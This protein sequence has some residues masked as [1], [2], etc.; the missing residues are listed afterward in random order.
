VS[1]EPPSGATIRVVT[2]NLRSF[3]DDVAAAVAALRMLA[4]DVLFAQELPRFV[5]WR[6][7]VDRFASAA[8]LRLVA[9]GGGGACG[10]GVLA[11]P[12]LTAQP[13]PTIGRGFRRPP[14]TA[15]LTYQRGWHRRAVALATLEVPGPHAVRVT[16]ASIHLGLERAQR[17]RHAD[18]LLALLP[19][20]DRT[21]AVVV[22]GDVNETAD[23]P[24]WQRL[25]A[26]LVDL[27]AGGA[28]TF[29]AR[30]PRA[31]IDAVLVAGPV[32]GRAD[33][34]AGASGLG[35]LL[36]RATDHLP[37]VGELRLG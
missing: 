6:P 5:G 1:P 17:L 23:S 36:L 14:G 15:A 32:H 33:V 31:R 30:R 22:A 24:A 4:P 29:P 9:G 20:A 12:E 13:V 21:A 8:G 37:V 18:E 28:R 7:M 26:Q 3:R 10:T 19:L 2:W 27:G 25:T 34:P 11:R 35:P 16:V